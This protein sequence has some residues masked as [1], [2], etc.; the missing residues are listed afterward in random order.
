[1][2]SGE[3]NRSGKLHGTR[4]TATIVVAALVAVGAGPIILDAATAS[5]RA[6]WTYCFGDRAPAQAQFWLEDAEAQMREA[7]GGSDGQRR[8]ARLEDAVRSAEKGQTIINYAAE[9]WPVKSLPYEDPGRLSGARPRPDIDIRI[10][11][12]QIR[13]YRRQCYP[14]PE[15]DAMPWQIGQGVRSLQ[16]RLARMATG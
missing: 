13:V 11:R 7:L 3:E 5:S 14:I 4:K 9:G 8:Q 1:M 12:D 15:F 6:N 16:S 10:L 2:K